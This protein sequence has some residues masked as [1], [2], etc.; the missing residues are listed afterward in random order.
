MQKN[1]IGWFEIPVTDLDRAETFYSDFFGFTMD[2][3]PE[4]G[5]FTMSWFPQ[6]KDG[7]GATG[8]LLLG[9]GYE[10][11]DKGVLIYFTAPE[12][13]VEASV[14][15]AREMGIECSDRID[16]GEHGFVAM[17]TDSE[18]NKIAIH[19]MAG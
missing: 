3:K 13:T 19:A 14:K 12:G 8:T 15:K 1:P 17:I 18:G 4:Q 11:T 2:R 9:E 16:I 7:Y 10:P 6:P 5:G